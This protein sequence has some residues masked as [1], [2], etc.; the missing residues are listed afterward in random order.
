MT[1]RKKRYFGHVVSHTH[2]D[3]AWYQPFE[4]FR[5]RLVD[6]MDDVIRIFKKN[7]H[8]RYFTL[9]GQSVVLEDYLEIR[10][11]RRAEL[12]K[13]VR[14]GKLQVGPFYILPDEYLVSGEA[15]IRN[16]M[17][18][19]RVA[20]QFGKVM[21]VG[22]VPDPFGHISQLPQILNGFGIHT[23]I[24]T[25]GLGDEGEQLG[26]E[27]WWV[28]PDEKSRVLAIHQIHGYGNAHALGVPYKHLHLYSADLSTAFKQI[29]ELM[30]LLRRYAHTRHVLLN[31]GM[32]HEHPQSD[33]SQIID[34]VNQRTRDYQL[35]QSTFHE[36]LVNVKR[37]RPRLTSV[38]SELNKGRYHVILSGVYSSRMP[39][40][41]ANERSQA[42][43]EKYVEPLW[44]FVALYGESYPRQELLYAW[45]TLLKNH[46]HDDICGCSIDEVHR[47]MVN[48]FEHVEQVG[49]W[50]LKRATHKLLYRIKTK[51]EAYG[52]PVV[53]FNPLNWERRAI[54]T[55][56]M[57]VPRAMLRTTGCSVVDHQGTPIAAAIRRGSVFRNP[58]LWGEKEMQE[59]EVE[60]LSPM[61]PGCGYRTVYIVRQKERLAPERRDLR[62]VRGGMENAFYR[63]RIHR[64]G[65][66]TILD[67][68]TG[69]RL[70]RVHW[71]EDCADCGDEYD[72]SP[73]AKDVAITTKGA[74]ADIRIG[75]QTPYRASYIVR[76]EL[77]LPRELTPK[78]TRRSRA[79]V[80]IPIT[81]EVILYAGI[82]RIEFRTTLENRARD[83][84]L[85]VAFDTPIITATVDVESSFDVVTRQI[86]LPRVRGWAQS[87]SPTHHQGRF[88]SVSDG[89]RGVT[90]INKGL[91][92]Y[93]VRLSAR[94]VRFYQTLFRSIGWLSRGD[95]LTRKDNA[96]PSIATPDAQLPGFHTFEYALTTHRGAWHQANSHLAAYEHNLPPVTVCY[97]HKFR[98][99]HARAVLPEQLSFLHVEPHHIMISAVKQAEKNDNV[100]VRCYNPKP[101]SQSV[102]LTFSQPPKKAYLV[103]LDEHRLKRLKALDA[104]TVQL[105]IGKKQIVTIELEF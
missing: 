90:F 59:I 25:R 71:F 89:K 84:R 81:T 82:K 37:T 97:E 80:R 63:I 94:G 46:P 61:L 103:R 22:Y 105:R 29:E 51:D 32:D 31:N 30:T 52:V 88:A 17:I 49:T 26:S 77:A 9:D 70:N 78:R 92:E 45:K 53:I 19:H 40:K 35:H 102:R 23:F 93:E 47:D 42:L 41:Q 83:H 28:G 7:K 6:L 101:R 104:R 13:L 75:A 12:M 8:F 44:S 48:R 72:F 96:G 85:R 58:A 74:K 55:A 50:Q 57:T 100:I 4:Q 15:L 76:H 67:K 38:C 56:R 54:V 36:Y 66:M 14:S 1:S 33:I 18:G 68:E 11:Q 86:A 91:P 5:L 2:W 79:Q 87:P 98:N 24:F 99:L 95:L 21:S 27:F 39:L 73:L 64:D 65:T 60:L 62:I 34:Y 69:L 43:L 20:R 16:L 10:P 3:R